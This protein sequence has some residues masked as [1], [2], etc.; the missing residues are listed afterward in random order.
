MPKGV[1]L[2]FLSHVQPFSLLESSSSGILLSHFIFAIF[3]VITIIIT[4]WRVHV[5][6]KVYDTCTILV[7]QRQ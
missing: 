5:S 2:L 6:T 4:T 3:I 7:N 1:I